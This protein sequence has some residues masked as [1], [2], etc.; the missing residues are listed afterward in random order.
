MDDLGDQELKN[1]PEPVRVYRVLMGPDDGAAR[2]LGPGRR[3]G[4]RGI[5]VAAA[6]SVV[7]VLGGLAAWHHLVPK[8]MAQINL[9]S[10]AKPSIAVLPFTNLS[11]DA[12]EDYFS[13]GITND[14]I[15]DLSKFKDLLVIAS[16]SVFTYKGKAV[17]VDEV[18]RDLGVRYV[19]EGSVLKLGD[20]VR[21]NAQLIDGPSGQ[22]LWAERYDEAAE[23]I[24]DLQEKITVQ[25]V[26]TLSVRLT[27]AERKRAF[28]KPTRSLEAYDYFLR[29]RQLHSRAKRSANFEAR[30]LFRKAVERDPDYAEAYAGLAL[31]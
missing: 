17:K 14:I 3:F 21:I 18:S 11:K 2:L 8:D 13:D 9:G 5:M 22:H 19:L 4:R 10:G 20:R 31:T 24:Y 26:R 28:A 12:R 30:T 27:D 6:A 23:K 15:T 25:I 1:I 29:G 16:N 7:V